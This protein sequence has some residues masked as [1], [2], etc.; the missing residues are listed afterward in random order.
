MI[1]SHE[2]FMVARSYRF[3]VGGI[4]TLLIKAVV[5]LEMRLKVLILAIFGRFLVFFKLSVLAQA[6]NLG[7]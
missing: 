3:L 4:K 7:Q 5:G 2:I 6:F 1:F